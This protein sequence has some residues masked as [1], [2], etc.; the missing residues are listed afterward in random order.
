MFSSELH[1]LLINN[2]TQETRRTKISCA[3]YLQRSEI[4][5][6]K[7]REKRQGEGE[8]EKPTEY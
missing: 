3:D 2:Q 7:R 8:K 5:Q 4:G 6:A 1:S